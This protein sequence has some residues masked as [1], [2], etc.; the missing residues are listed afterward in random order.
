VIRPC[1]VGYRQQATGTCGWG[2]GRREQQYR[3]APENGA[4]ETDAS[5]LY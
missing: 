5:S 2:L 1:R 3:A 4:D